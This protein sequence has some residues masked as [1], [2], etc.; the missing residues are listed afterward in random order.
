MKNLAIFDNG[1]ETFDR[2]TIINLTD[3]EMIAASCKPFH[4]QGFG[5]HCGN[6]AW[7][8]FT[9]TVG[10]NYMRRIQWEDPKHYTRLIKQKTKEIVT[11]FKREKNIGKPVKF[12]ALPADVQQ[13]CKQA[14]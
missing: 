6:P 9:R 2:F 11:E 8:Y 13:F 12:E 4:P 14:F 7:D 5:Q 3:G 10:A 1:G